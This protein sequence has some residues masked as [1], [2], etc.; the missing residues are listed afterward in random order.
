[1]GVIPWKNFLEKKSE[2]RDQNKNYPLKKNKCEKCERRDQGK[3]TPTPGKRY[4]AESCTLEI[5]LFIHIY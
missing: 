5:F 3:F 1:V 2:R 4:L